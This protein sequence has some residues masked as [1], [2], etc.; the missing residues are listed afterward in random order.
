ME[1]K[2]TSTDFWRLNGDLHR[3]T[4]ELIENGGEL[5]EDMAHE[6]ER[7]NLKQETLVDAIFQMQQK[8]DSQVV[9]IDA[10]IKRLQ[11]LKKARQKSIES[12]KN[13][14]L[15][16]MLSNGIQ[17]VESDLINAKVM[18]GR[19]SVYVD[20]DTELAPFKKSIESIDLPSW[21]SLKVSVN[22]TEL[23]KWIKDGK[24]V[25]TAQ[26]VKN[27]YLKLG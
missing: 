5:T 20:E 3:I 11:G 1:N 2:V 26:I 24:P 13:Y 6:I 12:L 7:I 25:V 14:L 9:A 16:Y 10:E 18:A 8:T 27:P 4:S 21:V 15:D 19:E 23:G 17:A 22:K